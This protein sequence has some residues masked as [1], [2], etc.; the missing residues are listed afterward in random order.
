MLRNSLNFRLWM[1][2]AIAVVP[3]FLFAL[4][5]Y[6]ERREQAID[7][8]QT[9]I[10]HRLADASRE[11]QSAYRS[12]AQVLRI[13]AASDDLASLDTEDC[14]GIARRLLASVD[15]FANIGAALPDGRVF[16]SAGAGATP[17][18]VADRSWFRLAV[19]EKDISPGE[20]IIGRITGKPGL[21]FG[22]PLVTPAGEV[23]AVIFASITLSWFDRLIEGF[24]LP[25]G[26]EAS[27]I[28]AGGQILA[29]QPDAAR[30]REAVVPPSLLSRLAEAI[31]RDQGIAQFAG[32]DGARRLYGVSTPDFAPGSGFMTIGAPMDQS[33][34]AVNH[35]FRLHLA[36][37]AS[38]ALASAL[39]ARLYV[40]RL[41]EVWA[42]RIRHAVARIAD[43]SLVTRIEKGSGIAE[44]D[45]LSQGINRM[46]N[47]IEK[48]DAELRRLSMVVERSPE[49]IVI[50]DTQ[51]RI[52]YA[53][54]AF[55]RTTGYTLEEIEGQTPALLNKG[56]TP[57]S[58]YDEMWACLER[59]EVWRGEFHNTRKDGT[60]YLELATILPIKDPSGVVT[61]YLALKEDITQ[62]KQS[63]ALLHRLA[64]YD[65][66]TELPNRALLHDR[67]G[68]AIRSNSR[69]EHY[70]MLML[71]DIDRFQQLNDTLGHPAGDRL[72]RAVAARLRASVRD[73][74][75]V[76]RH[77]DDD[78]AIL[79]EDIGTNDADALAH[80]EQVARKVQFRLA[81][82][83]TIGESDGDRHYATLS[84]GISLFHGKDDSLDTLLK[85]A[86]VALY[87]AK[88]GGRHN[89][90]FFSPDMQAVVD[91]HSRLEARMHEALESD[92]FRLF[93]QPQFN[94]A[95]RL[96]GAE[97]LVRWPLEDGSM[98]SPADFIPLAEDTGHI[99]PLGL[100][101]IR[102]ACAQLEQWQAD[103]RT[104]HLTIAVNVSARQF[105]QHEFIANVKDTLAAAKIDPRGLKFEL[106]ESAI[107]SD[108]DETVTRMNQLR[109]IGIQFALDDFGTGYSSLSYLKRL[110]FD[111]LKID[112]SFVRDMARDAS[113]E[114]IV[115]AVLSMSHALG[116]EVIAEGVE[117]PEQRE[118]LNRNGCAFYQGYL[119]GRPQP[120]DAWSEFF[121][122]L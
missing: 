41:I 20:F 35:R 23:R 100:W 15:G 65:A 107:L 68:Q 89:I 1:T 71:L 81:A 43:G 73:E 83:Y 91:A 110:P 17:V 18:T 56:L 93:Y 80:A 94:R 50:T 31:S 118:F 77:G 74:D 30:W 4:I 114:A 12:V 13:M 64:Y 44:L 26:W 16:C 102:T 32:M 57:R 14:I 48:R 2:V 112:Q 55:Q 3:L 36:A 11:A 69:N 104:R 9:E 87:R 38:L 7:D 116:M 109:E 39:V 62:R 70:G 82:P 72:L 33:L 66:L 54:E 28:S 67:I 59:G 111:Q 63:E 24:R 108:L 86:E 122:H 113:S 97:A 22:Y 119:L 85:Q 98:I 19:E 88:Q 58:T 78:F 46:A 25:Q 106:T 60:T 84:M 6:Q 76:A 105:H 95:G 101:V 8:I 45:A 92:A 40:Y 27:V 99:V 75:T 61:H 29:H 120:I 34:D 37:I 53:N 5:D 21:V 90:C 115:L 51:T 42:S 117:T 103:E 79:V 47:E 96:T 49:S 52:V 10:S 121:T